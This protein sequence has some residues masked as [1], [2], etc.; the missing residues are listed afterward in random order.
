MNKTTV[1]ACC[2]LFHYMIPSFNTIAI[3]MQQMKVKGYAS[4][5]GEHNYHMHDDPSLC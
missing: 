1:R 2:L 3:G 4:E 5:G